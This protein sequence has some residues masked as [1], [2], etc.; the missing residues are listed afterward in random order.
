MVERDPAGSPRARPGTRHVVCQLA[1]LP[2]GKR[3][4]T[5]IKGRS[6]GVLHTRHGLFAIRNVCPHQGAELG[7]GTVA[8]TMLPSE[9]QQYV[10]GAEDAILR[11]PWH[12]WEFS[13]DTGRSIFDPDNVRVKAYPVAVEDGAV[14]VEVP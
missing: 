3:I 14:V 2:P 7:R 8:N 9:P 1:D 10:A 11:C 13:L 5:T 12:G 4:I 6:I